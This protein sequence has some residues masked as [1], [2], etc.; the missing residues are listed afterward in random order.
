VLGD[1]LLI[2]EVHHSH[3]GE[4]MLKINPNVKKIVMLIGGASGTGKT[5]TAVLIQR[6]LYKLKYPSLVLSLDD[7]YKTFWKDRDEIRKVRGIKSVGAQ[8]ILWNQLIGIIEYFRAGFPLRY[9][10]VNKFTE[11]IEEI[12]TPSNFRVLIIEGLYALHL[13]NYADVAHHIEGDPK[14][15]YAF[16]KERGKE[17]P[18]DKWRQQIVKREYEQVMKLRKAHDR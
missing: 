6:E 12:N 16:R 18:D 11:S 10:R 15:T 17:N 2:K 14:S 5:E 3:A 13:K 7:Y 4:A 9:N 1:R 8:E